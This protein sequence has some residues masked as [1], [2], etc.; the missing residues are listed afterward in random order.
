MI[1]NT[2][3]TC[4]SHTFG[5]HAAVVNAVLSCACMYISAITEDV[6]PPMATPSVCER[7]LLLNLNQVFVSKNSVISSTSSGG[8]LVLLF[9]SWSLFNKSFRISK[10]SF[11]G[12]LVYNEVTSNDTIISSSSTV[13][14]LIYSENSFEF[15]E[16]LLPDFV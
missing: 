10:V 8:I 5:G 9:R 13:C 11:I 16:W 12:T 4:R 2:S 14:C 6:G 15:L 3:S 1:K 7:K